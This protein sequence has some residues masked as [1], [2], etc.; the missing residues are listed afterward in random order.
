MRE[1]LFFETFPIYTLSA[2]RNNDLRAKRIMYSIYNLYLPEDRL[3]LVLELV[4]INT[5]DDKFNRK[6]ASRWRRAR[7]IFISCYFIA[8]SIETV[9]NS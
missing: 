4:F 7:A 3:V 8:G 1:R 9:N 5:R 6:S 2:L